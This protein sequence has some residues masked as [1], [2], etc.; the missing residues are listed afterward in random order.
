MTDQHLS[1]VQ[2]D[3]IKHL[4]SF[5]LIGGVRFEAFTY[6]YGELCPFIKETIDF[7]QVETDQL[8]LI[9]GKLDLVKQ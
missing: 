8:F 2:S 4:L 5:I 1:Q 9:S 7:E 6:S 3:K